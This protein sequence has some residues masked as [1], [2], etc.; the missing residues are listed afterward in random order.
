MFHIFLRLQI[1]SVLIARVTKI[2]WLEYI[3]H[4]PV[5]NMCFFLLYKISRHIKL[6][7][8]LNCKYDTYPYNVICPTL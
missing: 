2:K 4:I 7:N 1:Y 8:F 5:H 6:A 3:P